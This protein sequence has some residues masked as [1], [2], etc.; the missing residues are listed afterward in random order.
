MEN[1]IHCVFLLEEAM[2]KVITGHN[3]DG[4]AIFVKED[5]EEVTIG[6]PVLDWHEIWATHADDTIPI[7][8]SEEKARGVKPARTSIR[9]M[10][11]Q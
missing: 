1:I 5:P 10:C 2:K 9:S 11:R 4:K 6:S 8:V 3:V 7:D